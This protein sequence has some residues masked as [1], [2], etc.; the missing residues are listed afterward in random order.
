MVGYCS[1]YKDYIAKHN[2]YNFQNYVELQNAEKDLY[3]KTSCFL[4]STS[5]TRDE[6]KCKLFPSF[7]DYFEGDLV[8]E[9]S[10]SFEDAK[11]GITFSG[12]FAYCKQDFVLHS[13]EYRKYFFK[14]INLVDKLAELEIHN[15]CMPEYHLEF[16]SIE[17]LDNVG[18]M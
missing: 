12:P 16:G 13:E 17:W 7:R 18:S 4:P 2:L 1:E 10:L 3:E 9:L 8:Q 15:H 11:L 6:K 14:M 5:E